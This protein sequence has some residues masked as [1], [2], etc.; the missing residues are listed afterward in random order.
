[1]DFPHYPNKSVSWDPF[2]HYWTMVVACCQM[3]FDNV[4]SERTLVLYHSRRKAE[5]EVE[6][7]KPKI[8]LENEVRIAMLKF[9]QRP[10]RDAGV[11]EVLI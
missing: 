5:S 3:A 2:S 6:R 9:R 4:E 11:V 7:G 10:P 8:T 1:M